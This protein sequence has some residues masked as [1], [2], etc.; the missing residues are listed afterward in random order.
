MDSIFFLR[1]SILLSCKNNKQ[2]MTYLIADSIN[3]TFKGRTVVNSM[4]FKI[5]TGE[6]VGLIGANGAGKTTAFNMIAGLISCDMGE[7]FLGDT[8]LTKKPM[9]V[10]AQHGIGY[11]P[12]EASIFRKLSVEDN[13]LAIFQL[14]GLLTK[15]EM[16]VRLDTILEEFRISHARK[17]L[18]GSL[19]GGERRRV[20][21]A[22][23]LASDPMFILLD[24][25]F[26]GIDPISVID[27][28]KM[29]N[30]LSERNI[31]VFI[32]DHSV[33]DTLKVCHR[34]YVVDKGLI[35]CEGVPDLIVNNCAVK[36]TYLGENFVY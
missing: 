26:A 4:S 14:K 3:K 24:E 25:P 7:I 10:R 15:K 21:I 29:I 2:K 34:G 12:Q 8:C 5:K 31:G 13:I 17:Q 1:D 18:G 35:I 33:R 28:K 27:I 22:R 11:L 30:Q 6:V 36:A 20:E 32:T 19:S 16:Q 23:A 9:H